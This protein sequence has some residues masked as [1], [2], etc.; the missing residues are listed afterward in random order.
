LRAIPKTQHNTKTIQGSRLSTKVHVKEEKNTHS[1]SNELSSA[2]KAT[3]E[4]DEELGG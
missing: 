2:H 1:P 4:E 3:E